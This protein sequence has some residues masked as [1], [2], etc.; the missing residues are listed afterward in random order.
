MCTSIMCSLHVGSD[1]LAGLA[2]ETVQRAFEYL[3]QVFFDGCF[4][5]SL[6]AVP[7]RHW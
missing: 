4:L 5:L 1:C 6:Q 3:L 2:H 7:V